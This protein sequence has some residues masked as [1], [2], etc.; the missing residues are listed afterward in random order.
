MFEPKVFPE[1]MYCTE[2][3]TCDIVGTFRLLPV[4]PR[5]GHCSPLP[6]SLRPCSIVFWETVSVSQNTFKNTYRDADDF[7]K[8]LKIS[9]H[10]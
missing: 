9:G 4:I 1:Q 8:V 5:P 6:P 7:S 2:E 3:S 10:A